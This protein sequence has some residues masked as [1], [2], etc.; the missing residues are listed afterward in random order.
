MFCSFRRLGGLSFVVLAMSQQFSAELLAMAARL[1]AEAQVMQPPQPDLAPKEEW[2]VPHDEVQASGAVAKS[3]AAQTNA[4]AL[5]VASLASKATGVWQEASQTPCVPVEP[6]PKVRAVA[7]PSVAP[8]VVA[9]EVGKPPAVEK[10]V[11]RQPACPPPPRKRQVA[12]DD[13]DK[14]AKRP[15]TADETGDDKTW[16]EQS[17]HTQGWQHT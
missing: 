12:A 17:W 2:P 6:L 16:D 3:K 10:K 5:P 11:A 8:E 7:R 14:S 1:L 13:M 9:P 4:M 15:R